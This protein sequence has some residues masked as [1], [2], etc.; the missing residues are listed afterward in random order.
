MHWRGDITS[1]R[2]NLGWLYLA[3]VLDLYSRCVVSWAFSNQPNSELSVRAINL[4]VQLK[5]PQQPVL[6][7]I[8]QDVQYIGNI[9]R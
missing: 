8:D 7:H 9:F 4:V 2:I 3:I 1:I 5:Q 6:F